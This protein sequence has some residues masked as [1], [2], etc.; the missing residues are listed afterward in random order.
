MR[1]ST[2]LVV[3]LLAGCASRDAGREVAAVVQD[4][5]ARGAAA[6]AAQ[7]GEGSKDAVKAGAEAAAKDKDPSEPPI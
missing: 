1:L 3:L 7:Q 5:S 2:I 6:T 4:E